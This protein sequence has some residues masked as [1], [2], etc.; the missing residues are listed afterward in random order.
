MVD[1]LEIGQTGDEVQDPSFS[2]REIL[3]A[4]N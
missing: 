3:R 4:F 1:T 2:K